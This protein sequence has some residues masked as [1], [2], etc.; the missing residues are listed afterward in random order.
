MARARSLKPGFFM[1]EVL[2][3]VDPL[4]RL[5]FQGLWCLADREGRLEDRPKRLKVEIL[6]YDACDIEG[7]LQALQDRGFIVRYEVDGQRYILVANFTRHQN[8]HC[9]EAASSIPAP[10]EGHGSTVQA[11]C[12]HGADIGNSGTSRADS[13]NPIPLTPLPQPKDHRSSAAADSLSDGFEQFWA[14]YPAKK[15]KPNAVKAWAKLQPDERMQAEILVAIERGRASE[16]W[17]RDR[18]R[19]IPYPATWLNQRRWEDE[20]SSQGNGASSSTAWWQRAGFATEGDAA[21]AGCWQSNW[22]EFQDGQRV[23]VSA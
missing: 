23:E 11:Q 22:R 17:A 13:L 9:K 8:P 7:L 3:E 19:F 6:P 15:A 21:D 16:E 14:A 1:N 18:G 20:A 4:G 10:P 12:S 2:A 5:L